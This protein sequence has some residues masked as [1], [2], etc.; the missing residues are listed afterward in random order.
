[1]KKSEKTKGVVRSSSPPQHDQIA[2]MQRKIQ[3]LEGDRTTFYESSQSNMKKNT[4]FIHQLRLENKRLYKQLAEARVGDEHI[5]K[6]FHNKGLEKESYRNMS[7]KTALTTL[8]QK[9]LSKRKRLNAFKHTTQTCQRRLEELTMEYHRMKPEGTG[10]AQSTDAMYL[11]ALENSL[12][13]TQFKYKEAENIMLNYQE[14]KSYLQ[15]ESLTYPGKL[16]SLEAEVLKHGEELYSL[17]AMN[18]DAQLS[19][20]AAKAELHH[21]E[22]LLSKERKE[23]D[24]IIA[25]SR[26]KIEESKA[27]AEKVDRRTQR[28]PVQPDEVSSEVHRGTTRM[29][30]EEEEKAIFTFEEAFRRIKEA[31]GVTDIQEIVECF[32]SQKERHVHLENLKGE[33]EQVLQ[34]L[35]EQK[36][37]LNQQFQDMKYSGEAKLSGDQQ[38][39]EDCEQQL[40]TQQQRCD[41][42]KETLDWLLKTLSTIRGGVKHLAEKLQHITLCEDA[43]AEEV[44]PDSDEFVLELMTEC[45]LKLQLLQEELRG[46]DLAAIMKEMEEEE[47][48][49]SIEE[50]LPPYNTRVKLPEDQ[51]DQRPL[52]LSNNEDESEEDDDAD[53]ISR[54][55]VKNQ[56]QMIVDLSK[57]KKK[58]WNKKK[59]KF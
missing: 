40:Q 48:Y 10:G 56:S 46:K 39:L 52:D 53:I 55:A 20:E 27:Q 25:S 15:E 54:E 12:E 41:T 16:D 43:V 13:K 23:R 9:L 24:R 47:F 35:K 50:K 11:R 26:K 7:R 3:L 58:P 30:V 8:D 5:I 38:M 32:I 18:N 59:G 28:A 44:S 31:T 51:K 22:E 21:L 57:S 45:E 34:Q 6:A 19:K 4:E 14:L 2:E 17:Q 49:V 33:N 37:L 1:M 36:Q 42:A 29:A